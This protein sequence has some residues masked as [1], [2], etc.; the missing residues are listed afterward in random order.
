MH[1][2]RLAT[3]PDLPRLV[4]IYNQAIA[5]HTATAD[6]LPFTVD[7]RRAWFASHAPRFIRSMPL[8][9]S[10]ACCRVT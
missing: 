2:I 4:E 6:T 10:T 7:T 5:S 9:M 8:K 3:L 1:A